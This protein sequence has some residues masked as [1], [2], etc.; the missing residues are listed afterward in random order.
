M[1]VFVSMLTTKKFKGVQNLSDSFVII[2]SRVQNEIF[3]KLCVITR[4]LKIEGHADGKK[5][6]KQMA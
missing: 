5:C 3:C 6:I 4:Y 2:K 1:S